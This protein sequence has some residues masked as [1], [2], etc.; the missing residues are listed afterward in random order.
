MSHG[1]PQSLFDSGSTI[2]STIANEF[3]EATGEMH[4]SALMALGLVLFL[5]HLRRAGALPALLLGDEGDMN[6]LS[7]STAC[8]SPPHRQRRLCRPPAGWRR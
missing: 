1:F 6:A 8:A 3:A 4:A 5:H 7:A 2:A